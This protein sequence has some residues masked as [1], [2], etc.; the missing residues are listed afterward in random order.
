MRGK[1]RFFLKWQPELTLFIVPTLNDGS[2]TE[3]CSR[4]VGDCFVI[5]FYDE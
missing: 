1:L 5:S 2:Q 4:V 3:H